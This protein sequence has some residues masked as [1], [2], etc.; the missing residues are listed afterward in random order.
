MYGYC[1][2]VLYLANNEL[3]NR[4]RG[5]VEKCFFTEPGG[6]EMEIFDHEKS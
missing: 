6:G 2:R 1:F 4:A 5:G 3:I